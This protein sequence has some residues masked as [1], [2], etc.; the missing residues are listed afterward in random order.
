MAIAGIALIGALAIGD[1]KS[2]NGR[3]AP[4]AGFL[5][6]S[7]NGTRI[8]L[9]SEPR[10][11]SPERQLT[12][13]AALLPDDPPSVA[14]AAR[15][16]PLATELAPRGV[17]FLVLAPATAAAAKSAFP[18][19]ASTPIDL[20]LDPTTV[21]ATRLGLERAATVIVLDRHFVP[22]YRGAADDAA[23][24]DYLVD[25]IESGLAEE[26][27]AAASTPPTGAPL[28]AIAP[29]K[30]TFHRDVEPILDRHCVGCHRPG[31]I[32][33]MS[34]LDRDEATGWAPTIAEVTGNGRM[35]PWSADP[36][37]GHFSNERRLTDTEKETLARWAASGAAAGDPADAPPTPHFADPEWL[38]GPPDLVIEL[39][40]EQPISATEVMSYRYVHV[41]PHFTKDL[42]VEAVEVRPTARAATHHVIAYLLP[43]GMT[44]DQALRDP[45]TVLS[46]DGLAGY[47]PGSP[48]L[49][50]RDGFGSKIGKGSTILFELHYTPTGKAMSD[51]TRVGIRLARHPVTHLVETGAAMNF[52][53][54]IPPQKDDSTFTAQHRFGRA[55]KLLTLTPHMHMRGKAMRY[56]LLRTDGT[57]RTLLDVP[58]YD[59]N[60]QLTYQLQEAIAV[61]P[62]DLL[63]VT[64]IYDNSP[65]NPFNPDPTKWVTWG[66]QTFEEMLIGY[67]DY[68][69]EAE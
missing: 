42:L 46:L 64:A 6:E 51:R 3:A 68:V 57:T 40:A 41:D 22:L 7:A 61:A 60:W 26:E 39:P 30:P 49:V 1:G 27:I 44:P 29:A 25:A 53:F 59:F 34:L 31:Q 2:G 21:V 16:A 47:A 63:R 54:R 58:K 35:P 12:V 11:E 5:L 32:G 69:E 36:R 19:L 45:T 9:E 15:L 56:E 62:G 18:P 48:P 10:A 33:P 38:I 23:G 28:A 37:F 52:S 17:R 67:F 66:D 14:L 43:P 13:I 65:Q 24:N 20:L 4:V 8:A 50:Y 55:A